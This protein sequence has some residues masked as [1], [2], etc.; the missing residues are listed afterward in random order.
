MAMCE[1]VGGIMHR[2]CIEWEAKFLGRY[3][4]QHVTT[5]FGVICS[6]GITFGCDDKWDQRMLRLAVGGAIL[7]RAH[8]A[9]LWIREGVA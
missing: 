3:I 2:G 9:V 5:S 1:L 6:R 8:H 4:D 7:Q